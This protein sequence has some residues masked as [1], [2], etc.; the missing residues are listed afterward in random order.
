MDYFEE[1]YENAMNGDTKAFEEIKAGAEVGNP[2]AMHLLSCLYGN[3]DSPFYDEVQYNYWN[4]KQNEDS[5]VE[6]PNE[7]MKTNYS[8][9]WTIVDNKEA[10]PVQEESLEPPSLF[11]LLF[12][13]EGRSS[14]GEY[15]FIVVLCIA[16]LMLIGISASNSTMPSPKALSLLGF[17]VFYPALNAA[18]RRCHDIGESGFNLIIPFYFVYIMFAKGDKGRNEYGNVR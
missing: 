10:E 9:N 11:S 17:L 13:S 3:M 8:P 12:S 6:V 7:E 1:R 18:I 4:D 15:I 5:G 16:I 2:D 14:R